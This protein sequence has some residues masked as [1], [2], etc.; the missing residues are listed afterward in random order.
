MSI[1]DR[2][3]TNRPSRSSDVV[4]KPFPVTRSPNR[5]DV[6]ERLS[7][8]PVHLRIVHENAVRDSIEALSDEAILN[9]FFSNVDDTGEDVSSIID[10]KG[11]MKH[12]LGSSKY[13]FQSSQKRLNKHKFMPNRKYFSGK[14]F[15]GNK[16]KLADQE[17]ISESKEENEISSAHAKPSTKEET[18][19]PVKKNYLPIVFSSKESDDTSSVIKNTD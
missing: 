11:P 12:R 1:H 7:K 3:S 9:E 13:K 18:G 2:L 10:E 8:K 17:S 14:K 4:K 15:A 16:K 19:Q 6:H 5:P